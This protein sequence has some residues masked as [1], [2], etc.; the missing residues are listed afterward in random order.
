[1]FVP[2]KRQ[3]VDHLHEMKDEVGELHPLLNV[4]FKKLPDIERVHYNQG[5]NELGADF[6][7]YRRDPAL[8][9]TT[10]IG[11]VVK[12]G[13]IRQNTTEV[14]RQIKECFVPRKA[15]DGVEIQIKEVWV[16]SS[17]D[18]TKNARD[19][20]NK[21]YSDK[22]IEFIASQDLANLIDRYAPD[23]FVTTSPALQSF[24]ENTSNGIAA[25]DQRSLIVPGLE[26]FYVEP[27]VMRKEF[28][29]YG[30]AKPK[31]LPS[32]VEALLR[33]LSD[34][35]LSIIQA[36]A[37]GGKSRLARELVKT[38]LTT[39]EFADGSL[40]P[41]LLHSKLFSTKPLEQLSTEC[42]RVRKLAG[43]DGRVLLILDGFDELDM[44]DQDRKCFV[45]A[46]TKAAAQSNA[47]IVLMSRP[48]NE[49]AV[50][51]SKLQS[52]NVY[53]IEPLR[54]ARAIALLSKIA[55][56]IDVK[57]RLMS[58]LNNS[59]LL[60]ALEGAPIAYILLGKLIVDNQQ[61]LPSN[62]TELF[63]KYTE[64]V[65]GRWEVA[66]GLRSQQE[67][68]VIVEILTWLA[69]YMLDNEL[70]EVAKSEICQWAKAYCSDRGIAIDVDGLLRRM[71]SRDSILYGRSD[72]DVVGFRHR[73]FA[74]FFYAR[75]LDKK[76]D[77][78]LEKS[79]FSPYWIN[80]YYFLTGIKRDCPDLLESLLAVQLDLTTRRFIRAINFGNFLLAGYL[81]PVRVS[82]RAI[83]A[84][85]QDLADIYVESITPGNK[86]VFAQFPI[87]Q[88]LC[89]FTSSYRAQY[90]Y[91][92]F[93]D[94]L[95]EAIFEVE[96]DVRSPRNALT[97]FM[98]DNA[99]REAGG[100][101][102]FDSLIQLYGE[103][104]PLVVKLGITHEAEEM[105]SASDKVKRLERNLRRSFRA[106]TSSS[107]FLNKLYNVPVQDL[108]KPINWN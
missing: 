94:S 1:M 91:K 23:S 52:T 6:I 18:I 96:Q 92:H 4:L 30:N 8:L 75:S 81:T 57:S 38:C 49:V 55:G 80:T 64:I 107:T 41:V 100:D 56:Q 32:G 45:D 44:T 42:C 99:Y 69:V 103:A 26:T 15:E 84:M 72:T 87:L 65:L 62:L 47:C 58:D 37:G 34:S 74:E 68:E 25:E 89:F 90:G 98:L 59:P 54:G 66:K 9:R 50:L 17:Q 67:Y 16:V 36:G 51:S 33:A 61:D 83:V 40:L 73:A 35:S 60:R 53:N 46:M 93:R 101:L 71:T 24:A 14:E 27:V 76:S 28:D 63:Q 11:V 12:I 7:L 79:V 78:S 19:V 70:Y 13:T 85:A 86:G 106:N 5:N 77:V 29:G 102:R 20:L 48:F 105:K 3:T 95:E 31:K 82:K 97:L 2:S 104:L 88:L 39:P 10:C 21:Q 22:K 43:S 108:D